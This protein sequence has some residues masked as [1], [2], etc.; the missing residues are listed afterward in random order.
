MKKSGLCYFC[1]HLPESAVAVDGDE[2]EA[3][4][5]ENEGDVDGGPAEDDLLIDEVTLQGGHQCSADNGHDEEGGTEGGVLRAYV[6]EGNAVD[7]GEHDG[8][9]EANADEAVEAHH[10]FDADGAEGADRRPDA[11]KHEQTT[12]V[13]PLHDVG[14]HEAAGQR[15]RHGQ[16]VP[17]LGGSL[18]DAEVVGILD[19]EGPH[20]DLGG[21]IEHLSQHAIAVS[22]VVP[23]AGEGGAGGGLCV[24]LSFQGGHLGEGDDD[25][26]HEDDESDGDIRVADDGE[27]VQADVGL[28]GLGEGAEDDLSGGVALVGKEVRQHDERGNG[29]AAER[30]YGVEGL[31]QVQAAGGVG[32]VA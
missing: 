4:E 26:H 9:E 16:D 5:G 21:D 6:L 11:E 22:A 23:E 1:L 7:A 10:A 12:L 29:H 13:D 2:D 8:H 28:L 20:H 15:Q 24:V 14:A 30:A 32:L 17:A 25:E 3:D 19:D 27:V 31:C 18:V